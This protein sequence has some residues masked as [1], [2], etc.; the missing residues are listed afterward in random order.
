M[1]TIVY[2]LLPSALCQA[3]YLYRAGH[4]NLPEVG[5]PAWSQGHDMP[6]YQQQQIPEVGSRDLGQVWPGDT[7]PKGWQ[8][9]QWEQTDGVQNSWQE[10][11]ILSGVP[12]YWQEP[13]VLSGV[14]QPWQDSASIVGPAQSWSEA[15]LQNIQ[16]QPFGALYDPWQEPPLPDSNPGSW[17]NTGWQERGQWQEV[18]GQARLPPNQ[19]P[20]SPCNPSPAQRIPPPGTGCSQCQWLLHQRPP[21]MQYNP[22]TQYYDCPPVHRPTVHPRD[23]TT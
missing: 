21:C 9:A 23:P 22:C 6:G 1:D 3:N 5:L 11:P 20:Y 16:S 19:L 4:Q 15:Q 14:P 18:L 10:P 13:Q 12:Q 2:F 17:Q 7:V 8:E